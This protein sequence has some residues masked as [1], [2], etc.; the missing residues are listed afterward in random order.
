LGGFKRLE[1]AMMA[2]RGQNW[3][4]AARNFA[5]ILA[6]FPEDGPSQVFMAPPMEFSEHPPRFALKQ[7]PKS[8]ATAPE[9]P[10]ARSHANIR[11]CFVDSTLH[12]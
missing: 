9:T 7:H 5:N 1:E 6:S 4:E 12:R 11:I 2:Y 3:S 8:S 10:D